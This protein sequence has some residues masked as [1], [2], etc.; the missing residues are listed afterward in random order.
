MQAISTGFV[1]AIVGFFSSFPIVLQGLVAVGA[2]DALAAS[3]LMAASISMGLAGIL[4]SL[5]QQQPISVAW[6]TPGVALLAVTQAPEGGFAVAVAGFLLAGVF[7]I[8]AGFWRPL[9]RLIGAIPA[10]LAQAMLS[11][12]LLSLCIQPFQAL[13]EAPALSLPILLTWFV[14]SQFHRL[15]AV[16]AAVLAAALVVIIQADFQIP[17]PPTVLTPPHWVTPVFTLEA[18][19]N[20][21]LPLF[22][23]TMATQNIPGL[24]VIRSFG[25]DPT[26]KPLIATVGGASVLSAAWGAPATCLAAITAAI[27]ASDASHPDPR[28]RYW[29]AVVAGVIYCG[30]GLFAGVITHF[31]ALAPT[32]VLGTIAGIALFGVFATSTLSTLEDPTYRQ[33]AA[34]TLLVTASGV[35]MFGLSAA[36]WG[37]VIGGVVQVV[38]DRLGRH[39]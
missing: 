34:I 35:S 11:G 1:V 15:F 5:W 29:S 36:V 20:I 18:V 21:A 2:S 28:Q 26:P 31:A 33:A 23:V 6:S 13:A 16:P 9:T 7:T 25:Y 17:P 3:G 38:S 8:I 24:A 30:F 39:P 37:L 22:V 14:V 19:T 12:I 32:L 27:C 4:L 10:P